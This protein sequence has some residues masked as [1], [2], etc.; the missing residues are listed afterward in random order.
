M[1]W[2][3]L[4]LVALANNRHPKEET[5]VNMVMY[6]AKA[7]DSREVLLSTQLVCL[8][9]RVPKSSR[10]KNPKLDYGSSIHL[11]RYVRGSCFSAKCFIT[12]PC[13]RTERLPLLR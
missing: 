2:E 5:V 13:R 9:R 12:L 11:I 1:K 4:W 3:I 6:L 10:G 8:R 7:N